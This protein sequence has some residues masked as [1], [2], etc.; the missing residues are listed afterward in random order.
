MPAF[1]LGQ[2]ITTHVPEIEVTVDPQRP[3]PPGR[4]VFELVVTD[5]AGNASEPAR[6][7]VIVVDDSRPTAVVEAPQ[8]IGAGQ[9][10]ALSGKRS[11]D[12]APGRIVQ[13][14]WTQVS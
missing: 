1:T 14:R 7:E 13:Y 9:S 8:R 3:L 11:V 2:P 6:V 12:L 4:H 5:D 10:F